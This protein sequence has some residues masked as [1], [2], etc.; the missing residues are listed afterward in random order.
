MSHPSHSVWLEHPNNAW[1]RAEIMKL[2][3]MA[4]SPASFTLSLLAKFS[5]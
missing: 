4:F 3:I 2:L 1:W 5:P